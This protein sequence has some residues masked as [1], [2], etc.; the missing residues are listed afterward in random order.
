MQFT[1]AE[2]RVMMI[3]WEIREGVV[4]DILEI[5]SD[6]KPA[7]NTVSTVVRI[8]EKKGYVGHKAYG[9]VYQYHPLISKNE[10]SKV[11]LF[12]LMERYFDNSFPAIVSTLA[13]EKNLS[14][15]ELKKLFEDIQRDYQK[16]K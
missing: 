3:L 11:Q 8:L 13:H 7:H 1:K 16:M 5:F 12:R 6:P 10:Y 4:S 15:N 14:I 2:E 9:N